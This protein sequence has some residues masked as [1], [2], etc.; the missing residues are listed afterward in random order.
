MKIK[1]EELQNFAHD[2]ASRVA[3]KEG[4][5]FLITLTGEL[6]AGKTT[7][8]QALSR[9]LSVG[10]A[11][12]SPT[13]ALMKRYSIN[14]SGFTSFVHIDAYRLSGAHEFATLKPDTFLND[15]HSIVCIEWP[16]RVEEALPKADIALR[17]EHAAEEDV[18][19]ISES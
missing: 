13:F 15:P 7:L 17:F 14:Y 6:G 5:A 10:A 4:S 16:E 8:V 11:I 3:P 12:K 1:L 19:E 9:E 18:R 2:I